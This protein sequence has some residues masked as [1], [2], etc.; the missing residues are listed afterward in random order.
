MYKKRCPKCGNPIA[1]T[2]TGEEYCPTCVGR[3]MAASA[4]ARIKPLKIELPNKET[5]NED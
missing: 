1:K 5:S 4:F 2:M 3:E